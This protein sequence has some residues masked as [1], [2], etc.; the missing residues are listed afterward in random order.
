V[1]IIYVGDRPITVQVECSKV[2]VTKEA[3]AALYAITEAPDEMFK[4]F[5][6]LYKDCLDN[7]EITGDFF[8]D[9]KILHT[10]IG[11]G[12]SEYIFT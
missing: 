1:V 2:R 12:T 10:D 9:K 8:K 6:E 5:Q 4:E 3:L 11:E 7:K